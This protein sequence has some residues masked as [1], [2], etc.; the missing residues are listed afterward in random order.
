MAKHIDRALPKR[1]RAFSHLAA[2]LYLVISAF[3]FGCAAVATK[4]YPNTPVTP[5]T[6]IWELP[7]LK[8]LEHGWVAPG[9]DLSAY[10]IIWVEPL[11]TRTDPVEPAGLGEMQTLLERIL[12]RSGKQIDHGGLRFTG[13]AYWDNRKVMDPS[14]DGPLHNEWPRWRTYPVIAMDFA[15]IDEQSGDTLAKGR[16]FVQR[17]KPPDI[18][19]TDLIEDVARL[20]TERP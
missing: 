20:L 1:A 13:T 16:H 7:P 9:H 17:S 14:D 4:T 18:A 15:I 12:R 8:Y 5:A 10:R 3:V 6:E 2:W 19:M 11:R